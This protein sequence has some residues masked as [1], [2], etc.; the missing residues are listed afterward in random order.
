MWRLQLLIC[1]LRLSDAVRTAWQE[2]Q[3]SEANAPQVH[4]PRAF[5]ESE[6]SHRPRSGSERTISYF[7]ILSNAKLISDY[8]H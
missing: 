4:D 8:R 6:A 2:Q 1:V 7:T 3:R 5:S